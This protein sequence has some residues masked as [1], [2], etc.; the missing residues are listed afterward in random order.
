MPILVPESKFVVEILR[1][2]DI[3]NPITFKLDQ[4]HNFL[5]QQ[6]TECGFP[7][8]EKI[9]SLRVIIDKK[10]SYKKEIGVY[11][12]RKENWRQIRNSDEIFKTIK[13]RFNNFEWIL[14]N[15]QPFEEMLKIF[16]RTKIIIAPH[17]AGLTNMIFAPKNINIIEIMPIE[18]TNMCYWHQSTILENQ[19][20]I[21]PQHYIS[22]T[23]RNF[24]I[25]CDEFMRAI[26]SL[27]I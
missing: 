17:G 9:M 11:I 6:T 4:S 19:H 18:E 25:N 21:Y 24:T 27:K 7:S 2:F 8:P 26:I 3:K 14:F 22:P 16:S 10:I 20:Y 23:D 1:W 5:K 13:K 15:D 12:Y